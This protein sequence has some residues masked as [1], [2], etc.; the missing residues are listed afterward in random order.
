MILAFLWD[1][2]DF[3]L[4]WRSAP[5]ASFWMGRKQWYETSFQVFAAVG[6]GHLWQSCLN[7]GFVYKPF[8]VFLCCS[9]SCLPWQEMSWW[10][11]WLTRRNPTL[12]PVLSYQ[13]SEYGHSVLPQQVPLC[14]QWELPAI[15]CALVTSLTCCSACPYRSSSFNNFLIHILIHSSFVAQMTESVEMCCVIHVAN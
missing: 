1:A 13:W 8:P 7:V 10:S 11:F 4:R 6:S 5:F 12:S 15:V 3:K 2:T 9:W 14:N